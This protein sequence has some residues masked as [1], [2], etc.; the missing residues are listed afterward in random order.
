MMS[1][2]SRRKQPK[3]CRQGLPGSPRSRPKKKGWSI[4]QP[5]CHTGAGVRSVSRGGAIDTEL[6]FYWLRTFGGLPRGFLSL[7]PAMVGAIA[8]S[9]WQISSWCG[10]FLPLPCSLLRLHLIP[11]G[12]PTI[13]PGTSF[14]TR[15]IFRVTWDHSCDALTS[16]RN[17]LPFSLLYGV[18]PSVRI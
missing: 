14:T 13:L 1:T 9:P 12:C 10:T 4:W 3:G 18:L 2:T 15:P 5:M 8:P 16:F 7:P 11:P 17:V 6:D